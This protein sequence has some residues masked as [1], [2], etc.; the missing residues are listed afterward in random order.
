MR[1]LPWPRRPST[2]TFCIPHAWGKM[3]EG[4]ALICD[5]FYWLQYL[6]GMA[7]TLQQDTPSV[8]VPFMQRCTYSLYSPQ[9]Q[10]CTK[11]PCQQNSQFFDTMS[12][13]DQLRLGQHGKATSVKSINVFKTLDSISNMTRHLQVPLTSRMA[14]PAATGSAVMLLVLPHTVAQVLPWHHSRH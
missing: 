12:V 1:H 13:S 2:V 6:R 9:T 5:C 11:L 7:N 3:G 4:G 14:T 10:K 8:Q